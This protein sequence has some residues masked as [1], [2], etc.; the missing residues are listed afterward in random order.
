MYKIAFYCSYDSNVENDKFITN[1]TGDMLALINF[2]KTK[3]YVLHTLDIFKKLNQNPDICI[4]LDIPKVNCK[5]LIDTNKTKSI[6]LLRE[7]KQIIKN[8]FNKRRHQE[9]DNIL[10]WK[11]DL[12]DE[13]KYFFMNCGRFY[14]KTIINNNKIFNKKLLCTLIN[15]NLYSSS[16]NELYSL[17]LKIIKWFEKN[18]L[19]E[20]DL[21]GYGWDSFNLYLL[22][23]RIFKTK[24]FQVLL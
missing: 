17:R 15:S 1:S 10:T 2:L 13:K 11:K 16:N 6:V 21:Y 24:I 3:G 20:F 9:F 22:N 5:N 23:K 4:F 19:E 8:N 18:H 12:I 7:G 14:K